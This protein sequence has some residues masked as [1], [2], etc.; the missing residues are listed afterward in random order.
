M[1]IL[2][3]RIDNFEK[4]EILQQIEGFLNEE[5]F[6]QIATV[7]PEFILRAQRDQEF[8]NILNRCAL[9]V[10]DGVGLSYAF[11]RHLEYLK[12]R[13]A[14]ADLMQEIF[15]IADKKKLS[16]FLAIHK[17]GL[18]S[19]VEIKRVLNEKYPN[20]KIGGGDIDPR[21]NKKLPSTVGF[22]VVFCNFGF[23]QQEKFLN[24]LNKNDPPTHPN[25]KPESELIK[26]NTSSENSEDLGLQ[27]KGCRGKI[28]L[29]MGVGGSFDF[30]TGKLSRAPK[31]MRLLGLEW[32]YRLMLEPRYRIERV[33]RAVIVF[34]LR[35]IINKNPN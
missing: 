35:V 4:Q 9:N 1:E 2:G 10:A 19:Y 28:R 27:N 29:A 30:I 20:I 34:P 8:R 21:K 32:L 12:T 26:S 16:L 31:I 11:L 13:L 6:H 14:G 17:S 5:K 25:D 3:V 7:N 33:L 15:E 23:P 22:Q 18:S 24:S